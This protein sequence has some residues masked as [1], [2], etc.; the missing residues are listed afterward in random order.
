MISQDRRL[1]NVQMSMG[2]NRVCEHS[3]SIV[4]QV[5]VWADLMF[6]I[7]GRVQKP[8]SSTGCCG[9]NGV[10]QSLYIYDVKLLMRDI[11]S[12]V[13]SAINRHH[14][15]GKEANSE[16]R[17]LIRITSALKS[18]DRYGINEGG[19]FS[20]FLAVYVALAYGVTILI[21][22]ENGYFTYIQV[23]I[24]L[25]CILCPTGRAVCSS[26]TI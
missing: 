1:R 22:R 4:P 7:C 5:S 15:D 10:K 9:Y 26:V 25:A 16:Q 21:I 20:D 19:W 6:S 17:D 24:F 13:E 18:V 12:E 11:K 8:T 23:M 2:S 3:F 14:C